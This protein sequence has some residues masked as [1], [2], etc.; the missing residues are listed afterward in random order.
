[1]NYKIFNVNGK[2]FALGCNHPNYKCICLKEFY[3][4]AEIN[5]IINPKIRIIRL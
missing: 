5:L 3:N 2:S 4:Q 1:M